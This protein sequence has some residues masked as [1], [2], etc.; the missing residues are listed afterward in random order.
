VKT[1]HH[2]AGRC[3]DNFGNL[4]IGEP[5]NI[6]E[7]DND[8]ELFWNLMECA[9]DIAIRKIFASLSISQMSKVSLIKRLL[10]SLGLQPER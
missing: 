1:R 7:I 10:K 5:F 9:L 6:S 2:S 8:A 3:A 4:F